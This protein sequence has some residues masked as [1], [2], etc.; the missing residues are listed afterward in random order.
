M[1]KTKNNT[2][3][4]VS[5]TKEQILRFGRCIFTALVIS[6]SGINFS[7]ADTPKEA[8]PPITIKAEVNKHSVAIGDKI[9]YTITV[10][11]GKDIE[12]EF[13]DFGKSLENFAIKDFGSS[14]KAFFSKQTITSW[15]L[16][17]TY[18][19][20]ESTIPKTAIK[21]RQKGQ[22]VWNEAEITEQKITVKSM[23]EKAGPS[24]GLRDIKN[25]VNLPQNFSR[26][27]IIAMLILAAVLILSAVF[28]LKTKNAQGLS[29]LKPAHEIAYEQLEALKKK[30]LVG[31]GK[32]K[33][34]YIEIS[35]ITRHYIENR[36]NIKAPEM[37]TEEFFIKVKEHPQFQ[38]GHK[39]L[40]KEFLVF[41]D[42][43][44]F[45]KYSPSKQQIDSAFESAEKFIG[46][47]KDKEEKTVSN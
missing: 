37:T 10:S 28:L 27:F 12:V 19:T 3:N 23:L 45:A 42:L 30:D 35:D 38:A 34:F 22:T 40:L 25:P 36:F 24:A 8:K 29:S 46:Q 9:K 18:V 13:P 17:D 11:C 4:I 1:I 26:Y 33:E 16:L 32:I 7:F 15:Y 43:V 20:G 21:Y 5:R 39:A 44:K 41:C 31:Q 2:L 6:F 14:R 47:T